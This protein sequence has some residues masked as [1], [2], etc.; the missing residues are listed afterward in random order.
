VQLIDNEKIGIGGRG[1][2]SVEGNLELDAN[3]RQSWEFDRV[4]L[5]ALVVDTHFPGVE[6]LTGSVFWYDEEPG[7]GEGFQGAL[8]LKLSHIGIEVEAAAQFGKIEDHKYFFVDAYVGLGAAAPSIGVMKFTGFGG[9]VSY[10][11]TLSQTNVDLSNAPSASS[12]IQLPNIGEGLSGTVFTPNVEAGLAIKATCSLATQQENIFNGTVG[13]SFEFSNTGGIDQIT[14]FG[15]GQFLKGV[16]LGIDIG[17]PADT[18]ATPPPSVDAPLTA[19]INLEINFKDGFSLDGSLR[20]FLNAGILHGD[21]SRGG[22]MVSADLHFSSTQWYI[23]IGTPDQPSSLYLDLPF[24][25]ASATA[26]F[27]IG[28]SVP[29][30]PPLPDNVREIAYKVNTNSSLRQSGAGF[31]FGAAINVSVGVSAGNIIEATVEGGAGFDI[32]LRK[33]NNLSCQGSDGPVGIDGWYATG[34]IWAYVQ[35]EI[36]IFGTPVLSAGLA[37]VLQARLPNPF[38]AQATV[39]I[40]VKIGFIK[41]KKSLSLKLGDDCIL[42]SNDPNDEIGMD[43]IPYMNPTTGAESVETNTPITAPVNIPMNKNVTISTPNGES[44]YR[45]RFGMHKI[46]TDQGLEIDHL[47]KYD[48]DNNLVT[49]EPRSFYPGNSTIT[50]IVEVIVNKDDEEIG[51]QLDTTIFTTGADLKIIPKTN[52]EYVYPVDGMNN[53]YPGEDTDHRGYIKMKAYQGAIADDLEEN[54]Y[55][56]LSDNYGNDFHIPISFDYLTNRVNF[57]I[58]EDLLEPERGYKLE[59]VHYADEL[60]SP[61]PDA[62]HDLP[63]PGTNRLNSGGLLSAALNGSIININPPSN[64]AAISEEPANT[65]QVFYSSYFRVSKYNTFTEKMNDVFGNSNFWFRKEITEE[66]FDILELEGNEDSEPLVTMKSSIHNPQVINL[67]EF[68][69]TFPSSN[70]VINNEECDS[71]IHF[72]SEIDA[73]GRDGMVYLNYMDEETPQKYGEAIFLDNTL[74][75]LP[76]QELNYNPLSVSGHLG[77]VRGQ[78][79]TCRN[80]YPPGEPGENTVP[81]GTVLTANNICTYYPYDEMCNA[82][83]QEIVKWMV[84]NSMNYSLSSGTYP[85]YLFYKLPISNTPSS[86]FTLN[87]INQ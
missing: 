39:G 5:N 57:T 40:R 82:Y 84:A 2:F 35:G 48:S 74:V 26:Y 47:F 86:Q 79:Q 36:K 19:Y 49:F 52:V 50:A 72:S 1:I 44:T 59:L 53:F 85:I 80:S 87:L 41:F 69:N 73:P 62:I 37:A 31:V 64:T 16:D 29:P 27:D 65:E 46:T 4:K 81:V 7:Y 67:G 76:N 45:V 20:T 11:M 66:G 6:K 71:I 23:F 28:T 56:R 51:T 38:F 55:I 32:S 12:G 42:V 75:A 21:L 70:T 68:Y 24:I 22:L 63:A 14:F 33:Y 9:G 30:M 15:S 77:R 8:M 17:N 61:S 78:L 83:G 58:G 25:N 18:V 54:T 13:L 3:N 43:I 60:S 10:G 34:Q